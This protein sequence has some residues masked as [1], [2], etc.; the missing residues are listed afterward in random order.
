MRKLKCECTIQ[1]SKHLTS[2]G[3][4]LENILLCTTI[5]FLFYCHFYACLYPGRAPIKI[6]PLVCPSVLHSASQPPCQFCTTYCRMCTKGAHT[7]TSLA[8]ESASESLTREPGSDIFHLT[9]MSGFRLVTLHTR[10]SL[11][12]WNPSP[13]GLTSQT[14]TCIDTFRV[15]IEVLTFV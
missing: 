12:R 5:H 14:C 2:Q 1:S 3:P 7:R 4:S 15:N 6:A 11:T 9:L 13:A 10:T 8:R